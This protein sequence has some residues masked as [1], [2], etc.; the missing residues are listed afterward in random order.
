MASSN[1]S[2]LPYSFVAQRNKHKRAGGFPT[3]TAT[4]GAKFA[5]TLEAR[6]LP[7]RALLIPRAVQKQ[8]GVF[9]C[10]FFVAE[11]RAATT[12][13]SCLKGSEYWLIEK[14]EDTTIHSV[15][16]KHF[17]TSDA[18]TSGG[19]SGEIYR[20]FRGTTCYEFGILWASTRP[21]TFDPGTINSRSETRPKFPLLCDDPSN[22][23]PS[24][25]STGYDKNVI[26]CP[27]RRVAY[28]D[29]SCKRFSGTDPTTA[30]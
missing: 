24:S 4:A 26:C 6:P 1:S 10:P 29:F 22:P 19:E 28:W 15:R 25:S 2:I 12:Q 14:T 18:W 11:V 20:A 5:T 27:G 3:R 13:E 8:A 17:T 7:S 30:L 21:A 16:M 23:S 9:S